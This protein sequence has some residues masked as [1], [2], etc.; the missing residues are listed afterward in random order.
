MAVTDAQLAAAAAMRRRESNLTLDGEDEV[1]VEVERLA[2]PWMSRE[3]F[4][5][6]W[7]NATMQVGSSCTLTTRRRRQSTAKGGSLAETLVQV[8]TRTAEDNSTALSTD[9][10]ET[11]PASASG[12]HRHYEADEFQDLLLKAL[13]DDFVA[14]PDAE[15]TA[16]DG[17]CVMHAYASVTDNYGLR[18]VLLLRLEQLH[19]SEQVAV[20]IKNTDPIDRTRVNAF[21]SIVQQRIQPGKA[22]KRPHG[23][24]V[25]TDT[26]FL[27]EN[28]D[29]DSADS[30][31]TPSTETPT[32][33]ALSTRARSVSRPRI[34]GRGRSHTIRYRTE[35]S[36]SFEGYLNKKSDLLPNWK[37]TYCVLEEDTLAYFESREDFIS[38]SKLMGRVQIQSVEDDDIGKPNG[39]RIVTEGHHMNH[40]SS[41]T[42]FEKE[43]WKRAITV[44]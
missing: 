18:T 6:L 31:S 43:Q 19:R 27:D 13:G 7:A 5:T 34:D 14:F 2:E 26:L 24:K 32:A 37:V 23:R 8:Q 29:Q 11:P 15:R 1:R 44:R 16:S 3:L 33:S 25:D 4:Q 41:R 28:S 12:G 39:F 42:S 38:N 35:R 17:S 20:T 30:S 10:A 21:M 22:P 9:G 40:L 36:I